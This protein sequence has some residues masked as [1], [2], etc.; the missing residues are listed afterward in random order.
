M[1][2]LCY[3]ELLLM[4]EQP[5]S[6]QTPKVF[7]RFLFHVAFGVVRTFTFGMPW[8]AWSHE[9]APYGTLTTWLS[10]YSYQHENDISYDI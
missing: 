8:K 1:I 5:P 3:T 7:R 2:R 9:K 10:Q 4:C 6:M